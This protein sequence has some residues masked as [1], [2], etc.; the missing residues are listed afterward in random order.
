MRIMSVDTKIGITNPNTRSGRS[1][2]PRSVM[3]FLDLEI[4]DSLSWHM[5]IENGSKVVKVEKKLD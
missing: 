2:V 4:G 3:D 1:A 5:D